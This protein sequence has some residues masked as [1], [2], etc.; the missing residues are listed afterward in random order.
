MALVCS[1]MPRMR[2]ADIQGS[3]A[4]MSAMTPILS[5]KPS[6]QPGGEAT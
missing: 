6:G 1:A 4:W 5:A 3:Q 2:A